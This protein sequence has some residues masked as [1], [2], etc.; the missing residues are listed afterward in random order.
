MRRD[1]SGYF[2]KMAASGSAN[3]SPVVALVTSRGVALVKRRGFTRLLMDG[4][5]SKFVA[6]RSFWQN[7]RSRAI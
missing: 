1:A 5:F 4:P 7:E 2:L 3:I 6:L